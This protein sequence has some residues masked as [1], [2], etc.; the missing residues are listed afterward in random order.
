MAVH[1][2]SVCPWCLNEIEFYKFCHLHQCLQQVF[3]LLESVVNYVGPVSNKSPMYT[4]NSSYAYTGTL[5][6]SSAQEIKG[7]T[8]L[9][10]YEKGNVYVSSDDDFLPTDIGIHNSRLYVLNAKDDLV[11]VFHTL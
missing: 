8:F 3:N 5:K 2:L 10:D 11:Y 9:I 1:V 6:D 4:F 7:D